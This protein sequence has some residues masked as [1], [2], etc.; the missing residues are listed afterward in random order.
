MFVNPGLLSN[1]RVITTS[2]DVL[3]PTPIPAPALTDRL[4]FDKSGLSFVSWGLTT[5]H[6]SDLTGGVVGT[7]LDL[8]YVILAMILF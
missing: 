1:I 8:T 6:M 2:D 5:M 4:A 3:D 7:P